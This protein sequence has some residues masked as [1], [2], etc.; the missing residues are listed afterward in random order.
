MVGLPPNKKEN[1]PLNNTHHKGRLTKKRREKIRSKAGS[2]V[3][4]PQILTKISFN[5]HNNYFKSHPCNNIQLIH[6]VQLH[7]YVGKYQSLIITLP[8]ISKLGYILCEPGE[9]GALP[10][11]SIQKCGHVSRALIPCKFAWQLPTLCSPP[12]HTTNFAGD[13]LVVSFLR[14]WPQR[15]RF[16]ASLFP[17]PFQCHVAE[18]TPYSLSFNS[19][20]P[21]PRNPLPWRPWILSRW[22]KE[23]LLKMGLRKLEG[24]PNSSLFAAQLQVER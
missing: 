16:Q 23:K 6:I 1:S 2:L 14:R 24:T 10:T 17:T 21:L 12:H 15:R 18:T 9:G 3:L 22:T 19:P 4:Y 20:S 5:S 13:S 7:I 11:Q 8:T